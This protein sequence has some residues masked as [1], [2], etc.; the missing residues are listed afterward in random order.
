MVGWFTPHP[1]PHTP[2]YRYRCL[3]PRTTPRCA[4]CPFTLVVGLY[5]LCLLRLPVGTRTR[6]AYFAERVR[7]VLAVGRLPHHG[8]HYL[9]YPTLP[10]CATLPVY[11]C[12]PRGW[13]DWIPSWWIGLD[14]TLCLVSCPLNID[15]T[16][17]LLPYIAPLLP[18][19]PL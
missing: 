14:W 3:L 1:L 4:T 10:H 7:C 16:H 11:C 19:V 2:R 12:T 18:L 9:P 15:Y 17:W 8:P 5:A 6:C 13:I